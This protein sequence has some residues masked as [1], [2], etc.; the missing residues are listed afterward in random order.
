MVYL[1]RQLLY[2]WREK[3]RARACV[4]FG[5]R[6]TLNRNFFYYSVR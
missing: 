5:P 1:E 2:E 4:G 3:D 6:L